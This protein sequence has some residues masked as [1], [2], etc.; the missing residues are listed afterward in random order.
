MK[1]IFFSLLL[2]F[3]VSC[4]NKNE[5]NLDAVQE[6]AVMKLKVGEEAT[7]ESGLKYEVIT[8]GTG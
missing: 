8:L 3:I 4:G 2:L 5:E 6:E 1:N 7:T